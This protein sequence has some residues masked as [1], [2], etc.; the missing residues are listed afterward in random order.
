M[1]LSRLG[2]LPVFRDALGF[3]L[4][5]RLGGGYAHRGRY[6]A[7]RQSAIVTASDFVAAALTDNSASLPLASA[8]ES[9][10]VVRLTCLK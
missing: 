10:M 9:S 5:L 3:K 6:P 4:L 7:T 1:S 8:T 2:E